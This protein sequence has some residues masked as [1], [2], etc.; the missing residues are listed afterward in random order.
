MVAQPATFGGLSSGFDSSYLTDTDRFQLWAPIPAT[1]KL[2]GIS[3]GTKTKPRLGRIEGIATSE[4]MDEDEDIIDQGGLEWD[5]FIGKGGR[6]GHGL[7]ILEHP[8]GVINTIGYPVAIELTEID[9]QVSG[10]R[11]RAT[12]VTGDLYL[13]DKFG[14][15]TYNKALV[16]QR[17]GDQRRP[18]FSIEGGV[19]KREGR[20]IL[21]GRVKWLAVTMAPRNHDSWW[22]P[23]STGPIQKAEIGAPLQGVPYSGPLAP[24]VGQSLQ[25]AVTRDHAV[26]QIAKLW[27][28]KLTWAKAELIFDQI[29]KS[30]AE[31]AG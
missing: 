24:L 4:A 6:R 23:A 30:L 13:E 25:G 19:K 20:R 27:P 22:T 2:E 26:M 18:G 5:Y 10:R 31:K 7:I 14:R 29:V 28:Q 16:M 17:A 11:E 1:F 3:K 15:V 8:V 21:K 12:K 9:S